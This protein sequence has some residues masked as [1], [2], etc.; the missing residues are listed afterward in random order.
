MADAKTPPAP[1]PTPA[2]APA[3]PATSQELARFAPD[4]S[5]TCAS[6]DCKPALAK[7][8]EQLQQG[9]Q[10][11]MSA[12][13]LAE[14]AVTLCKAPSSVGG[15]GFDTPSILVGSG[16]GIMAVLLVGL[17]ASRKRPA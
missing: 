1:A 17:L 14:R 15:S 2:T 5:I 3:A 13:E 7:C 12:L 4:G 8:F 10:Q 11:R 6:D 16:F 9:Q